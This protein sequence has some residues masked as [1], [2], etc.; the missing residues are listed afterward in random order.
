MR[1]QTNTLIKFIICIVIRHVI[2]LR[3]F[4]TM[5]ASHLVRCFSLI[6]H[7]ILLSA[8][9]MVRLGHVIII[10]IHCLV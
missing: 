9:E 4:F 7:I 6:S 3:H 8:L 5:E 2:L 1:L 10:L